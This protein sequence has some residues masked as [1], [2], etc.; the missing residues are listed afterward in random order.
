MKQA[1]ISIAILCSLVCSL[2]PAQAQQDVTDSHTIIRSDSR[3]VLVDSVV[4]DKKGGYVHGLT[5]KDFKVWEDG[6]EQAVS[7][8]SFQADAPADSSQKHYLVLFFDNSTVSAANQVYARQAAARFIE[9]NAGPNRLMSIVEFGGSLRVAQNFTDDVDRLKKVAS[10]VKFAGISA[11]NTPGGFSRNFTNYST[12][13][14]LGALRNMAQGLAQVPGRKT[15]V[16]ISQGFQV[17][18]ENLSDLNAAIDACNHA[19]V[20]IYPIDVRGL[21]VPTTGAAGPVGLLRAPVGLPVAALLR[22]ATLVSPLAFFQGRGGGAP[23]GG[24]G[25]PAG[26]AGSSGGARAPS[27]PGGGVN[28]GGSNSGGSRPA[29]PSAPVTN[30]GQGNMG[31]G[32][33]GQGNNGQGSNG[34][35]NRPGSNFGGGGVT[36]TTP[37][38]AYRTFQNNRFRQLVPPGQEGI[39]GQE[40]VLYALASGTGGFVI[41]NTNDLLGGMQKIGKEQNEYYILGYVPTREAEPGACHSLKVKVDK[42]GTNVRYRT[43]Y[44]DAKAVDILSGTPTQRDLEARITGSATPTVKASM[45]TPFFFISPNTARVSAVLDIPGDALKFTKEKGRFQMKMNV[46]G[47]AYL[48]DGGVAARFSDSVKLTLDDKKQVEAFGEK[49]FRYEK[50]FEMAS[51]SYLMKVAFSS[52][53]DSFGKLEAPLAME[54][55]EP[56][57]FLLSGLALGKSARPANAMGLGIEAELLDDRVPLVV[58][59]VQVTPAGT[60]HF[61]KGESGFIY[62]EVYEPAFAIPDQKEYPAIGVQ[63]ELLDARTDKVNHDF[64]LLRVVAPAQGGNPAVP[65]GLKIPISELAAGPYKARITAKDALGRE[66]TRTVGFDVSQ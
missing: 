35:G 55:W 1:L 28:T 53:T 11:D 12:R 34:Q 48:P 9:S 46:V 2:V 40:Q 42:G 17:S 20:A 27:A 4:T 26:G 15:L 36:S 45:Q 38:D 65:V 37:L 60:S 18:R 62:A 29:A 57:K 66:F 21:V 56:G 33:N 31:Q 32:N 52:G 10:G 63:L 49:P 64:G 3:L 51:G 30:S 19:N 43:G 24:A 7:T 44:C 58:N 8:F 47:I 25:A 50:Q 16:L 13:N 59:G 39:G 23:S 22:T 54:Q 14:V 5:Q 41:A 61:R 6:K